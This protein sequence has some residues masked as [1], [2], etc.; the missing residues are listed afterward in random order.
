MPVKR[1]EPN[2]ALPEFDST[3][4]AASW[5]RPATRF[6]RLM[7]RLARSS[8][9]SLRGKNSSGTSSVR[10]P[11]LPKRCL[12]STMTQSFQLG[13]RLE[14][15]QCDEIRGTRIAI[16]QPHANSSI[17]VFAPRMATG[18]GVTMRALRFL[19]V[20]GL[21]ASPVAAEASPV[22][23]SG[24]LDNASSLLPAGGTLVDYL[25]G[26]PDL[27]VFPDQNVALFQFSLAAPTILTVTSRGYHD[28]Y[29]NTPNVDG[30]D[31]YVSIF[32]GTGP[33]ALFLQEFL[34]PIAP[35]DFQATTALLAAGSYTLAIG[36]WNNY[37]C[38][39]G[40]CVVFSG[41]L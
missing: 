13:T 10:R 32:Q 22:T 17:N 12:K 24:Y 38:G 39:N 28:V 15:G 29:G 4:P 26:P 3:K 41:T 31:A 14:F 19:I 11:D 35:G 37:A 18:P 27:T 2:P 9:K 16:P 21:L 7:N 8:R 1:F 6:R 34:N 36:M 5:R 23:Y 25:L 30:F 40:A 33:S 20:A